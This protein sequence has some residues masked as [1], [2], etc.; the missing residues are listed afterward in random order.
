MTTRETVVG[1]GELHELSMAIGGLT[2]DVRN[3]TRSLEE[4]RQ[5]AA[6]HRRDLREVIGA[7]SQSVRTLATEVAD[8][9]PDVADY[10]ERRAEARG[11]ARLAKWLYGVAL[12][13][14]S[15]VGASAVKLVEVFSAKPPTP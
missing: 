8:M 14:G 7:L 6:A 10:R 13:I 4:E 11:A 5:G 2:A 3:L 12:A 9:K 1:T 15:A